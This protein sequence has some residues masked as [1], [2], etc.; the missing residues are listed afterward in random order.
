[1]ISDPPLSLDNAHGAAAGV[2]RRHAALLL[3]GGLLA[4]RAAYLPWINLFPEEAYYW[5][6]SQHL[7]YGYLDHPPMVAWLI[8]LG[9]ACFGHNELGVRFFALACSLVTSFFAFR[10]TARL[11]GR[12][13]GETAVLL[14]QLLPFFFMSGWIMTPDAPLTACWAGTLYFLARVVFDGSARAWWGV[15]VCLGMGML[16]K[17]TA[18]LLGPA[19]LLFLWLDPPSRPWFRR[20]VPYGSVLLALTIFSPVIVW[21][22]AHHWASFAFQSA[23]R[24]HESRRFALPSLAGSI[25]LLLTPLGVVLAVQSLRA[26]RDQSPSEVRRRRFAQVFTLVPLLV[27]TV[28]SLAHRVKLNWTGPLWLA[29]VPGIAARLTR[30]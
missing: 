22:S 14:V 25:L 26:R 1:M 24:L 20:V 19:T 5:N 8:H 2:W 30:P 10:L 15:G 29:V 6:Y 3:A 11:Y 12:T 4:L 9:V 18:A 17:Y 21:N 28:F 16:S 13:A 7:D 23:G 27:F